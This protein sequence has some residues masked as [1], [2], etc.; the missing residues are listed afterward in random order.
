METASLVK[1]F[2]SHETPSGGLASR[3][4]PRIDSGMNASQSPILAIH[5][6][7]RPS[8]LPKTLSSMLK[9][10][11]ET[12]DVGGLAIKP[13]RHTGHT[14]KISPARVMGKN[15]DETRGPH[16]SNPRIQHNRGV[17]DDRRGLPSYTGSIFT[18]DDPHNMNQPRRIFGTP[19]H[20][21]HSMTQESCSSY[22]LSNYRSYTSLRSQLE[23]NDAQRPRSPFAYPTR[24]KRPG[25]RPSSPALADG[26]EPDRSRRTELAKAC[27]G[28]NASKQVPS[29]LYT[30]RRLPPPLTSRSNEHEIDVI[31]QGLSHSPISSDTIRAGVSAVF[32]EW[33]YNHHST[34]GKSSPAHS[35]ISHRSESKRYI[36]G[37]PDS[38]SSPISKAH[39][40]PSPRYYDYTEDFEAHE[41]YAELRKTKP[42][43][44][45]PPLF[46][47]SNTIPEDQEVSSEWSTLMGGPQSV[48][49]FDH[50][51]NFT[52]VTSTGS[53]R[54][55]WS[56]SSVDVVEE[57]AI[58]LPAP[59][60]SLLERVFPVG[61]SSERSDKLADVHE[62]D[63]S[64]ENRGSETANC[65]GLK[66]TPL[67]SNEILLPTCYVP[68]HKDTFYE[69]Q[70]YEE[71]Q[72]QANGCDTAQSEHSSDRSSS[73]ALS[74]HVPTFPLPLDH[75]VVERVMLSGALVCGK[76]RFL[77]SSEHSS[78]LTGKVRETNTL[79]RDEIE[80]TDRTPQLNP[81]HA[82]TTGPTP[83]SFIDPWHTLVSSEHQQPRSNY[84]SVSIGEMED[85][86]LNV[87]LSKDNSILIFK[88][89][90]GVPFH[91]NPE[92]SL[93]L[94]IGS[95]LCLHSSSPPT[96][97]FVMSASRGENHFKIKSRH[98]IKGQ[99]HP[100][101]SRSAIDPRRSPDGENELTIATF[102]HQTPR[103]SLSHPG[104]PILAPTAISPRTLQKLQNS[105]PHLMKT[106]PPVPVTSF[107]GKTP[108]DLPC[109]QLR[110]LESPSNSPLLLAEPGL[111]AET[112]GDET[113]YHITASV[114]SD[115]KPLSPSKQSVL[116]GL[117]T[118]SENTSQHQR[119][120]LKSRSST[121]FRC[122]SPSTA[123][124]SNS[125]ESYPWTEDERNDRLPSLT[126]GIGS[127]AHVPPKF[128]LKITRASLTSLGGE[129]SETIKVNR[130]ADRSRVIDHVD[131]H[132]PK[133]LFTGSPGI[134]GMFRY[135]SRH[136]T[137]QKFAL[138]DEHLASEISRPD[139]SSHHSGL[140][141]AES[142]AVSLDTG[143][144][145]ISSGVPYPGSPVQSFF[146]DDSSQIQVQNGFRRR[147]TNLRAR[148]PVPYTPRISATQSHDDIVWR[149]RNG[150]AAFIAGPSQ[151]NDSA[152]TNKR[153]GDSGSGARRTKFK[154]K[155]SGWY[156]GARGAIRGYVRRKRDSDQRH[157]RPGA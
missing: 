133:D 58:H 50:S 30:R 38:A 94:Q 1:R 107:Q 123:Y 9:T 53:I 111:M 128:K 138:C 21:S 153:I 51:Q 92:D 157:L 48:N 115:S 147:I 131:L 130:R 90:T 76:Q 45:P 79:P 3:P 14:P 29:S 82:S 15:V 95:I 112:S 81:Q 152:A 73:N 110:P 67:N 108:D 156:K 84:S 19:E 34:S 132:H 27:H 89:S 59:E 83:P 25:F 17:T 6:Q 109:S 145:Q 134:S 93:A 143:S 144:H 4:R 142:R 119:F 52:E 85:K 87:T 74:A 105:V 114:V 117:G 150:S 70:T 49:A 149:T 146:S 75:R 46:S 120:K 33:R 126:P 77:E 22:P 155:V 57:Q 41:A 18:G 61:T 13:Q 91:A 56:G 136:F 28:K 71:K 78:Q 116:D 43:T 55:Q 113:G 62:D 68:S 102:G 129:S 44:H 141:A 31:P 10:T 97:S 137:T 98:E 101:L 7:N 23:W 104:T 11:T 127:A 40:L 118:D 125:D 36:P 72:H 69:S 16:V 63:M 39:P 12:G 151:I 121:A 24:L 47:L 140:Q 99:T 106:L 5:D 64:Q 80:P 66:H 88:T 65:Q 100:E 35:S 135:V 122:Q 148:L 96:P 60:S 86:A 54:Q 42:E 32:P 139:P 103:K 8:L 20:R 124:P 154:N 26:G 37:Q 2:A